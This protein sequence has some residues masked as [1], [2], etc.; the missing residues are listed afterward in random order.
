MFYIPL[1]NVLFVGLRGLENTTRGSR[2]R[3]TI[4]SSR[5]QVL[6]T[7]TNPKVGNFFCVAVNWLTSGFVY[8]TLSL[9]WLT[10]RLQT[11]LEKKKPLQRL[12]YILATKA[13]MKE[14]IHILQINICCI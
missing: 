2:P 11:I 14:Q 6:T 12:T 3:L 7:R 10:Y 1:I 8:T 4:S 9:S 13:C 5:S